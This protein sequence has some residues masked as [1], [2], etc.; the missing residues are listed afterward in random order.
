[1]FMDKHIHEHK[2][3]F[4]AILKMS[5][6]NHLRPEDMRANPANCPLQGHECCNR[7]RTR[8]TTGCVRG[9]VPWPGATPPQEPQAGRADPCHVRAGPRIPG[10]P[11]RL[12]APRP[13]E[14]RATRQS[15]SLEGHRAAGDPRQAY[16]RLAAGRTEPP[17]G[18]RERRSQSRARRAMATPLP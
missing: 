10:L 14:P 17:R 8:R 1:M 11:G 13:P 4:A 18:E 16:R 6:P 7:G 9:R 15:S 3:R 2:D 12:R 5:R